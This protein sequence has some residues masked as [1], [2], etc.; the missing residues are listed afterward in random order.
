MA[1]VNA[2]PLLSTE[3]YSRRVIL[4]NPT[5]L[6]MALQLAYNLR[7]SELQSRSA[8]EIVTS[9]ERLYKKFTTFSRNF[10][11]IGSS[12]SQLQRTY[13]EAQGQ[14]S[15]GRGNIISQLEGWKKKGLTPSSEIA[16]ELTI[17]REEE[18]E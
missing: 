16:P 2:E 11:K 15:T 7:Q 10:V 12:I 13:E 8:R 14:L 5:N 9:A 6:L 18:E 4:I 1:A 17:D 3:A